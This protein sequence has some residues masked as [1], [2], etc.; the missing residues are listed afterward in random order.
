MLTNENLKTL[1][2][3]DLSQR[4]ANSWIP[5][6]GKIRYCLGFQGERNTKIILR[7]HEGLASESPFLWNELDITRM[8]SQWYQTKE[9]LLYFSYG[10]GKQYSRGYSDGNCSVSTA[11]NQRF[12][13]LTGPILEECHF[14]PPFKRK[15]WKYSA[16][17]LEND[18]AKKPVQLSELLI[19]TP[20]ALWF[21]R[22]QIGAFK[23]KIFYLFRPEFSQ[24]IKDTVDAPSII[25]QEAF[26]K[27]QQDKKEYEREEL[28]IKKN[29]APRLRGRLQEGAIGIHD[30]PIAR[31]NLDF[32]PL[33]ALVARRQ[34][35]HGDHR[36]ELIPLPDA[37][38]VTN[39]V[40]RQIIKNKHYL[41][42]VRAAAVSQGYLGTFVWKEQETGF[43]RIGFD[44]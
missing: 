40:V 30:E 2:S 39:P 8:K 28:F 18:V 7:D 38:K 21:R 6:K 31:E 43:F 37:L 44:A 33:E 27:H 15:N 19:V 17:E 36:H 42:L 32:P 5:Y 41:T 9:G 14:S 20:I 25:N 23:N 3:Q 22:T 34:F 29:P 24:E 10:T 1:T 16:F 12:I 35:Q 4:Y 11:V 13:N 26:S